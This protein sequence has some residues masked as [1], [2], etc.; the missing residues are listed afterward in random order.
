MLWRFGLRPCRSAAPWRADDPWLG[1]KRRGSGALQKLRRIRTRLVSAMAVLVALLPSTGPAASDPLRESNVIWTTPSANSSG[2]MPLGNGDIGLNLWVESN[3]DLL[4]YISKT[5]AWD[6]Q[7]RL[8]KLGRVRVALSPNPFQTGL[9]FRQE[10][11]LR[12]GEIR[13]EAGEAGAAVTLRV[14]VDANRPVI[15]LEA[16]GKQAFTLQA[17]LEL[18]RTAARTLQADEANGAERFAR[19]QLPVSHPDTVLKPLNDR[20]AWC[21]R[22]ETSVWAATLKHQGIESVANQSSDPLLHRTFGGAIQGEGLKP[23]NATTLVS[24]QP[25]KRFTLAIYPLT[26]QTGSIQQWLA[27]LD[28]NIAAIQRVG[29]EKARAEHG[30]WWDEFWNRSWIHIAGSRAEH[31]RWWDEFWNRS[32]I[33][34]AGSRADLEVARKMTRNTLPLRIGAD[35]EGANRFH[36]EM[37]RVAVY[38]RALSGTEIAALAGT[39]AL[40]T[41]GRPRDCAFEWHFSRGAATGLPSPPAANPPVK[42]VGQFD[43]AE[44]AEGWAGRKIRFTGTGYAEAPH[45]EALDLADAVTLEAW[46][47]LEHLPSGG[48]RILDKSKAGT[49]NGYLLDTYPGNSLRLIVEDGTL[50]FAANLPT[51]QWSHV[52]AVFDARTGEKKLYLNGKVVASGGA[53]HAARPDHQVVSQGYALQRFMNACAGRGAFPIKFNGSIF[54][55]EPPGKFDP[56]YRL[57]GGCYW[58]QNTRLPYWPMLAAGDFELMQPLFAMYRNALPL[59]RARTQIYFDHGG[60]FFPETMHFWGAYHNGEFGYGWDRADEPFGRT[61]NR[62]IRFYWCGGIELTAMMLDYYALTQDRDFLQTTLVPMAESILEFYAQHYPREPGNGRIL[63]APAQ[64]LETWWECENPMPEVAGLRFV[65]AQLLA[66][67]ADLVGGARL[68]VWKKLESDLLP[69]PRREVA[70]KTVLLPAESFRTQQNMENPELY[71]VFPFRV[72]GVGKADLDMARETFARRQFKGN[73]GW[74]QDDTQAAFLG[75]ADEARRMV[76]GRFATKHAGSRFPAFWGPN[77]D[78]IPD[79]DHG[80]NGLMALQTM[81]LQSEGRKIFLFPAWPKVW[82]VEFKLHAPFNTTVEGVYRAG[83]LERLKVTPKTRARDVVKL[84][85]Q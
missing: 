16:E 77:F 47:R 28:Q 20:I 40:P 2:S 31:G 80:G 53:E 39:P 45:C 9:P 8:L 42:F 5:D 68:A 15:R 26:A 37:G 38:R 17:K 79:Q 74:Q 69:I 75:L 25:R 7:A 72:F 52:A 54:T 12:E 24:S 11:K 81:L 36:G 63:F 85:P 73:H 34:I 51:N 46:I 21:H 66:M 29:W 22:N 62:Y 3:G 70:G 48:A 84:E 59:A 14:W 60:A 83:K 1:G 65:L 49:S 61:A 44:S 58:F 27:Q 64:A 76:T 41:A 67:P 10:L 32:W 6:E 56:D 19:D 35:S 55:V 71:A 18:W 57:W 30:R 43:A 13:I 50:T 33:H 82:D 4:F 78:W 23:T